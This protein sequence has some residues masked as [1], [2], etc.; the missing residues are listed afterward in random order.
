FSLYNDIR[1][2]GE[3][4][5]KE[6]FDIVHTHGSQDSW[7]AA[8]AVRF[9]KRRPPIIRTKHNI[10]P[11]QDHFANR[12]LYGK[13]MDSIICISGAIYEY[14]AAKSYIAREKL[15][16]IHSAVDAERFTKGNPGRIR[17]EYNLDGKF[18]AGI[19]G[20]LCQEKGHRFLFDAI[21]K[22]KDRIPELAL[23]VVGTGTLYQKLMEYAREL[24]I[25]ERIVFTG[26]RKDI[27]DVLADLDLFVMPSVSEGLG[28]AVLEAAAA[29]LPIIASNVGGIPDIIQTGVNG[30]LVPPENPDALS[31]AILTLYSQRERATIFGKAARE[32]VQRNFSES[33]LGRKTEE[34]YLKLIQKS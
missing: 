22:I 17:T 16:V 8:L 12:W 33:A 4:I 15:S 3:L 20:R 29:S 32:H 13:A 11:I 19:T 28:T 27:P 10:F 14:C 7:A 24:E 26:F 5:E 31:E 2:I 25:G 6:R 30:L 1:K 23:L 21:K 9:A 34:V 18:I